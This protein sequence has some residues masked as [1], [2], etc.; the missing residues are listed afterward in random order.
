MQLDFWECSWQNEDRES[1]FQYLAGYRG[2]VLPEFELFRQQGVKTVCDAACGFGAY[3]LALLSNGFEVRGF[4]I[5]ETALEIAAEGLRRFGFAPELK[6]ASLLDTGYPD[7]SFDG[8]LA[9][10]VLDHM[11]S[12]DAEQAVEGLFR[13]TRSGGLVMLS[14]DTPE[15]EDYAAP[16][17]VLPDGS[18]LYI[19]GSDRAGMIFRPC[20]GAAIQALTEGREVL[21]RRTNRKGNRIVVLKKT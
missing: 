12:S 5:S 13:I 9:L 4:D 21:S 14:F 18:M 8:V 6:R 10:S 16:H 3:T 7:E 20:D 19:G 15:A 1:L 17:E 11:R 2:L